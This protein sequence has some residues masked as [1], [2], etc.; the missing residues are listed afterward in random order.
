MTFNDYW[1]TLCRNQPELA[2]PNV[3]VKMRP[4]A[5]KKA[6]ERAYNVGMRHVAESGPNPPDFFD[7]LMRG[8]EG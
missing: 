7:A 4:W 6:L 3:Q 2:D 5:L 1:E 8:V